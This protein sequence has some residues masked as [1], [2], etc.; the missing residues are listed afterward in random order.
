MKKRKYDFLH[1]KITKTSD[2][3]RKSFVNNMAFNMQLYESSSSEVNE[4]INW[5]LC[6]SDDC[7]YREEV[8]DRKDI[9]LKQ[10][11][12]TDENTVIAEV[13]ENDIILLSNVTILHQYL[14][15]KEP[16]VLTDIVDKLF[17]AL[18]KIVHTYDDYSRDLKNIRFYVELEYEPKE[19]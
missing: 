15:G 4:L 17:F 7:V 8:K 6:M 1:G 3:E 14:I 18:D 13:W 12:K 5:L 2:F 9:K 19:Q 16:D 10:K 11:Q